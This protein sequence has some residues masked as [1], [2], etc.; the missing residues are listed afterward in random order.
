MLDEALNFQRGTKLARELEAIARRAGAAILEVA[1]R[2]DLGVRRKEDHSAVTDADLAAHDVIVVGLQRATPGVALLSEE[3]VGAFDPGSS[4]TFW[5]VDPLDGTAEFVRGGSEYCV[6]IGLVLDG[7]VHFGVV[8]HPAQACS[9]VG[10]RG[11]GAWLVRADGSERPLRGM[12]PWRKGEELQ[13]LTSRW[14]RSKRLEALL[15]CLP[16]HQTAPRG[17]AL[18]IVHIADAHAHAAMSAGGTKIWDTV[19]ADAIVQACGGRILGP[20]G[21]PLRCVPEA[22]TNPAWIAS[23]IPDLVPGQALR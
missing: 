3:D 22:L 10:V 20:G 16:P 6:N 17:A 19:A 11:V 7:E 15:S 5:A 13:V 12:L 2:P 8:H 21:I 18:K 9:F 1:A 23:A 4:T 14:H